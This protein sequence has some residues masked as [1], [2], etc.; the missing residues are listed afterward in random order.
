[1]AGVG[2][3]AT[4][5]PWGP[6]HGLSPMYLSSLHPEHRMFWGGPDREILDLLCPLL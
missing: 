6:V 2:G 1:M 5:C 4:L 3:R